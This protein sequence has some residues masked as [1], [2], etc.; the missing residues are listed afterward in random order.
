MRL[1]IRNFRSFSNDQL[2]E[3]NFGPGLNIVVGKNNS[4][5]S[6]VLNAIDYLRGQISAD[7]DDRF[8]GRSDELPLVEATFE[9]DKSDIR[10][11]LSPLLFDLSSKKEILT[12]QSRH[13]F[14]FTY[15]RHL[16]ATIKIGKFPVNATYVSRE[17]WGEG[18]NV[19]VQTWN[20]NTALRLKTTPFFDFLS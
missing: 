14:E 18:E 2:S 5:K 17:E 12:F 19:V 15:T 8:S 4:G 16:D 9:L 10:S 6:T 20:R 13:P 11:F 7:L 1:A 3:L